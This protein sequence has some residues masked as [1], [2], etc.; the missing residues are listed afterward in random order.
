SALLTNAD[1]GMFKRTVHNVGL[2]IDF[3]FTIMSR[4][5]MTLSFGYAVGFGDDVGSTDEYMVSLKIM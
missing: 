4:M 5:D 3:Q 1:S 2:Q